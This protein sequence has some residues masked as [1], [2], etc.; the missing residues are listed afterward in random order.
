MS[1]LAFTQPGDGVLIQ[2][3]CYDEFAKKTKEMGRQVLDNLLICGPDG[4]YTIDFDDFER[5][6]GEPRVRLFLLCSP[7]SLTGRV[8]TPLTVGVVP[9]PS[10]PV[11]VATGQNRLT[12]HTP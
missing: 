12:F 2:T 10:G 8:W 11:H 1:V 7:H 3:P 6:A 4:R 9:H 5:K